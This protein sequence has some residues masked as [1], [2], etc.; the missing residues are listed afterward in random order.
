MRRCP[1][2]E[3]GQPE[4]PLLSRLLPR[5]LRERVF[6]PAYLDLLLDVRE[7]GRG[8]VSSVRWRAN[9]L[10]LD[11]ARVLVLGGIKRSRLTPRVGI[12]LAAGV[13]VLFA[14]AVIARV[15]TSY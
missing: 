3:R 2:R 9:L 1:V 8:H 10:A 12:W 11:S 6:E 4:F 5:R 13:A 14:L 7:A 15:A